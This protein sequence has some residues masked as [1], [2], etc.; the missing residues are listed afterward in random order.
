MR[1]MYVKFLFVK[2]MYVTATWVGGAFVNGTAEA[3]FTKGLAWCQVPIGY[4][5]SLL[6]GM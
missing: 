1:I 5:L 4:S 2:Y 6:F 3:M